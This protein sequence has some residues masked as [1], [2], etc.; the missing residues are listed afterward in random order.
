MIS[1]EGFS[2]FRRPATSIC[3]N[4]A[5]IKSTWNYKHGLMEGVELPDELADALKAEEKAKD[6]SAGKGEQGDNDEVGE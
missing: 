4:L 6:K 3:L 1:G 5:Q 2:S